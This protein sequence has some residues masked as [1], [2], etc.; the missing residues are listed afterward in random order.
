[1]LVYKRQKWMTNMNIVKE[2]HKIIWGAV[3]LTAILL[4]VITSFYNQKLETL[5]NETKSLQVELDESQEKVDK[6]KESIDKRDKTI[7]ELEEQLQAKKQAGAVAS[8][9]VNSTCND[10]RDI[11]ARYDWNVDIAM[12]IMQAESGCNPRAANWNDNHGVCMG[13]FGL[14]QISCHGGQIYDPKHNIEVAYA[15]YKARG[16]Q[17]WGAYTNGSY[18]K[19]MN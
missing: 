3:C 5:E 8:A 9:K 11:V 10:Y 16:W 1:L 6:Q 17:P 15:K 12:A 4:F 14:F 2:L 13:S 7:K 19:Y 18:L